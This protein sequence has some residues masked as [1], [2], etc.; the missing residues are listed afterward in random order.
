[1]EEPIVLESNQNHATITQTGICPT[2]PEAMG[3]GGG[4]VPMIVERRTAYNQ[5]DNKGTY[6]EDTVA[7]AI[8]ARG[9]MYGGGH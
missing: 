4:Y 7:N 2:L 5:Q 9:G 6:K 1:M 3:R 8:R